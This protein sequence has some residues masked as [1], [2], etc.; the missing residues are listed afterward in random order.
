MK[1]LTH[2]RKDVS[3]MT[4]SQGFFAF[5]W[6]YFGSYNLNGFFFFCIWWNWC[7]FAD[8]CSTWILSNDSWA[9][10]KSSNCWILALTKDWTLDKITHSYV[11]LLIDQ[12]FMS[13]R[14]MRI[15][16]PSNDILLIQYQDNNTDLSWILPIYKYA[17]STLADAH[18]PTEKKSFPGKRLTKSFCVSLFNNQNCL[19]VSQLENSEHVTWH[20]L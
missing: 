17:K 12:H 1:N 10:I 11:Y 18:I 13:I 2:W 9:R 6:Q 8:I 15:V 14:W 7:W 3:S 4:K 5:W 19:T 20:M 16:F